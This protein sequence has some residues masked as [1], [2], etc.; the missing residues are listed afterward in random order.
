MPGS[1]RSSGSVPTIWP[2]R[3]RAASTR[4]PGSTLGDRGPHISKIMALIEPGAADMERI[5]RR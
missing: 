1:A 2:G 3:P 5:A 4:D